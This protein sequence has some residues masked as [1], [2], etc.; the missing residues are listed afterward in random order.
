MNNKNLLRWIFIE[1]HAKWLFLILL[2]EYLVAINLSPS[3]LT[4]YPIF[5]LLVDAM[6]FIPAVHNFDQIAIDPERVSFYIALTFILLIPKTYSIYHFLVKN[7]VKEMSQ[8]VITPYTKS[9]PV[10]TR[11]ILSTAN[12]TEEEVKQLPTVERS[13]FSRFFWSIMTL[14]FCFGMIAVSF[15]KGG[16]GS[17]RADLILDGIN[18]DI[19]NGGSTMWYQISGHLTLCALLLAVSFFILK[20]YIK[21]FKE[22]IN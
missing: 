10:K 4:N 6:S 1:S 22:K 14:L 16:I 21:Y 20:D 9:K 18:M 8:Y 19:A 7:P 2:F 5:N 3:I 17:G 11:Q 15:L 12:M 13:L